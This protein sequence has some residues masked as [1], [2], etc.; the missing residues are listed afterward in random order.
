M[1]PYPFADLERT[2]ARM[3]AAGQKVYNLSIGDP[4]LPPPKFVVQAAAQALE[5]PRAHRYP[6][7]RGDEEVRRSVCRWFKAR[8]SVE[9]DPDTQVCITIGGKEA[10]ANIA[11]AVVNPGERVAAPD[12]GYPV[13]SRAGC[14]FVEGQLVHLRLN[15]KKGFL[16]DLSQ[17]RGV[18]LLYLNYPNNPTAATAPEEFWRQ[19]AG[20][21]ADNPGVVVA[22]DMAYG[23]LQY[24]RPARSL[25]EFTPHAIEFHSLSKMANATGYRVGFAVGAPELVGALVKAKEE[26]D[27]GA[28]LPF[29]IALQAVL[30]SYRAGRPPAEIEVCRS[31]YRRR[32]EKV[33][34]AL[35]ACGLKVF[36]ADATFYV[37]FAVEGDDVEYVKRALE[38]GVMLTP[39]SAF[40]EGGRGWVRA[41]VTAPDDDID[42]AVERLSRLS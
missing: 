5:D 37:W 41:S 17:A 22:S 3:T 29:Q 34:G 38:V 11:R 23:E 12:P 15:A 26:T 35:K 24:D 2:A 14:R 27:S 19:V 13:F 30:D 20:F 32:R 42:A 39:G 8:F 7:S 40:G 28:P 1:P 10:L 18:R 36:T 31:T 16:P 6:S 9:L 25:L 4:D 33:I 21:V